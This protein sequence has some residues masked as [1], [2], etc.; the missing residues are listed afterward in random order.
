MSTE[1]VT[2]VIESAGVL[3]GHDNMVNCI[4]AGHANPNHPDEDDTILVSG[5]RDKSLIIWELYHTQ[6]DNLAGRP[7]KCLTGHN[8]FV[9]DLSIS[10]DNT[11]VMSSSWDKTMRLWDLRSGKCVRNFIGHT[12]EVF[13]CTF[14]AD[15][16]QIFSAGAEKSIKLWNTLAECKV[17]SSQ[18]QPQNNDHKDWVSKVRFSQSQ[19]TQY[20]ATV[21]W[22]GRLKVW[23]GIF[24]I[25][26]SIKAHDSYINA[27]DISRNGM[28]IA[29]GGK[30]QVIKVWDY[31]DLKTP[32]TELKCESQ[33]NALSFNT[34]Y[35][36]LAAATDTGVKIWD[37]ATD[38]KNL[39]A[40]IKLTNEDSKTKAPTCTSCCWSA[41]GKK[42]YVGC[43]DGNIHVYNVIVRNKAM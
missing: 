1:K 26:A 34:L 17:T 31:V 39:F 20:Y 36:W 7:L 24:R 29:T 32:K 35:Q 43:S 42:I 21:G 25:I 41:N 9:S 12:K 37:L 22:D 10:N 30:D 8:H 13:T 2:A 11:F 28:Y 4:V 19:K 40:Q 18:P 3:Q 15:N 6:Q 38:S 16:R 14:S 33:I 23:N 27:L 5:S